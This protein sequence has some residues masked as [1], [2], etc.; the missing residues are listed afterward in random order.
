MVKIVEEV[1]IKV[2][3][4]DGGKGCDSRIRLSEKKFMPT[5]GEGGRGGSV[6]IR[7]NSNVADLRS[8]IYQRHFQASFGT[9]GGSNHKKGKRG[10]DLVIQVPPGTSVFLKQKNYLIR[11]L[12]HDGEEVTVVEGGR[13][14]IGNEGGKQAQS[15]QAGESI[16]IQLSWKIPA[17]VFLVGLPNSGKSKFLNRLTHST[18]KQGT[19]PFTTKQPELGVYEAPDFSQI[20]L[21]ELPGL[22]R[23]SVQGHGAGM[24]FL[25]HLQRAKLVLF[26]LD[27]LS[28]F[29]G[30]LKEGYQILVDVLEHYDKALL[31][32]PQIVV[33]NKMD[34]AEARGRIE[35]ERFTSLAPLFLISVETG[36]GIAPLMNCITQKLKEVHV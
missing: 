16:E 24:D 36:E 11:D 5:G 12:A 21:C 25:K 2:K 10:E 32:I 26:M 1:T 27:P 23:E 7:A 20:R 29:A 3:A 6:R 15:G 19:Y 34:L 33:V 13:G 14:G 4:G 22:Y 28:T 35:K 30:S 9:P 8:L 18:A 17:D 31:R